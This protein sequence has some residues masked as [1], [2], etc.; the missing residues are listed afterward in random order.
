MHLLEV[1]QLKVHFPV[2]H[3]VFGRARAQVIAVDEVNFDLSLGVTLGLVGE[4]ARA[5][6]LCVQLGQCAIDGRIDAAALGR[7]IAA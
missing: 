1:R 3:G 4:F 6:H 7:R 2:K 5:L